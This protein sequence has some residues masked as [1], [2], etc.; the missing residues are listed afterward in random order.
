[1]THLEELKR[2]KDRT[3]NKWIDADG[4]EELKLY[5]VASEYY[6]EEVNKQNKDS[7]AHEQVIGELDTLL[8]KF[9]HIDRLVKYLEL[10]KIELNKKT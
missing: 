8:S 7:E 4:F 9:H 3:F 1:M 2:I 6:Q 5:Q 10:R